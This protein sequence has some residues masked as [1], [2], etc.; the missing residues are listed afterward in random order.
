[1]KRFLKDQSGY[2]LL[3]PLFIILI[4]LTF[5][6]VI[7]SAVIIS[8]KY[9]ICENDIQRA[10]TITVD[11]SM[12]NANVRDIL[13]DIPAESTTSNLE[14]NLSEMGYTKVTDTAWSKAI[15]GKTSYSLED[16]QVSVQNEVLTITGMIKAYLPWRITGYPFISLPV[17]VI[18]RA[19]YIS[20]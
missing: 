11:K 6:L 15:D 1:M 20:G 17:R 8:S 5:S 14:S 18:C 2:A 16:V 3:L 9:Q 12:E 13:L 4:L 10:A 19:F 7:Y